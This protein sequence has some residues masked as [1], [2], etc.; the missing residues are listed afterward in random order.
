MTHPIPIPIPI[1]TPSATQAPKD[2]FAS[3]TLYAIH[4]VDT[5]LAGFKETQENMELFVRTLHLLTTPV[6]QIVSQTILICPQDGQQ[7]S[8]ETRVRTVLEDLTRARKAYLFLSFHCKSRRLVGEN[9]IQFAQ[10]TG[11]VSSLL[12][13]QHPSI[14]MLVTEC[15]GTEHCLLTQEGLARILHKI[16]CRIQRTLLFLDTQY[17]IGLFSMLSCPEIDIRVIATTADYTADSIP[18]QGTK[19]SLAWKNAAQRLCL[20]FDS[21]PFQARSKLIREAFLKCQKQVYQWLG[22]SLVVLGHTQACWFY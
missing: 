11:E 17:G 14:S 3:G 10:Q 12:S 1:A 8:L 6:T 16:P 20:G 2:R 4:V 19:L 15:N 22:T 21:L 13:E 9:A 18:H 5:S 7:E